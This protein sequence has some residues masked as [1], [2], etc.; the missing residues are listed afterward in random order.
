MTDASRV[1][2]VL[3]C[4]LRDGGYYNAWDFR[5][6]LVAAY[7]RSVEDANLDAIELGFRMPPAAEYLGPFAYTTDAYLRDVDLPKGPLLGVMCNGSDLVGD[8]VNVIDAMFGPCDDSPIGLVRIAA[9]FREVDA[10]RPAVQRL[11]ELGYRVGFNVMQASVKPVDEVRATAAAINDWGLVEVLYFA[12]SLGDM[13]REQVE[14]LIDVIGSEW[15]GELGIHTHDNRSRAL[16][17]TLA[18]FEAGVTWLDATI[19]GMGRGAGNCRSDFLLFELA[20]RGHDR[21]RA[22]ALLE[23]TEVDF[24]ELQREHG[25]GANL[26]YFKSATDSIH[27]SYV[28]FMQADDRYGWAEMVDVLNV[29]PTLGGLSFKSQNVAAASTSHISDGDG[30]WDATGWLDGRRVLIVGSGPSTVQ[31]RDAI[32][33]LAERE[34]VAVLCLNTTSSLAPDLIDAY[35]ACHSARL[36]LESRRIQSLHS[37]LVAPA[38]ALDVLGEEHEGILDFGVSVEAGTFVVRPTGCTLPSR[39]ALGYALAIANAG[40]ATEILLVGMD[41][42]PAGDARQEEVSALFAAYEAAGDK[43]PIVALTPTTYQIPQGSI[44]APIP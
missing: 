8:P 21:Y 32:A 19:L 10:C 25:W 9:H 42:Y 4:T 2:R 17:N 39:L 35:V 28:Q 29:L 14:S 43:A 34:Q 37:K 3:D 7:F 33:S 27:P 13:N 44:Y 41:G 16:D 31:H 6:E 20:E 15:G 11:R 38:R 36:L 26:L 22:E 12:D 30:D 23:V 5:P 24:R 40:G 18:G 1:P